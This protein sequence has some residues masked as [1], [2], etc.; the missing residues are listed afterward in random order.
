LKENL[1]FEYQE[2]RITVTSF[3]YYDS[4][5]SQDTRRVSLVDA[6]SLRAQWAEDDGR[7]QTAM[8]PN[9]SSET[10]PVCLLFRFRYPQ[11][12]FNLR[13]LSTLCTIHDTLWRKS[14][15]NLSVFL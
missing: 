1:T 9:L 14:A 13:Q 5:V 10:R 3:L 11:V 15:H 12:H 7:K 4:K 8:R 6:N 2:S